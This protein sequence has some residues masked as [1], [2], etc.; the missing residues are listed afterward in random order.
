MMR[1]MRE[2]SSAGKLGWSIA[3][4]Y[5]LAGSATMRHIVADDDP[6]ILFGTEL[7]RCQS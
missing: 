2:R 7:R 5:A 3:S 4:R 6:L 1:V